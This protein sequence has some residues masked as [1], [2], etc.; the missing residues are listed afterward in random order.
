MSTHFP[1]YAARICR[2]LCVLVGGVSPKYSKAGRGV[3]FKNFI[4]RAR[5]ERFW[6]SPSQRDES[7]LE[8]YDLLLDPGLWG[9]CKPNNLP[10]FRFPL[11]ST[12]ISLT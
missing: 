2:P 7:L 1:T 3:K 5:A 6:S 12:N 9:S 4:L 11:N 10:T 8:N